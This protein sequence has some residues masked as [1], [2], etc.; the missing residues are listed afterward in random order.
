MPDPRRAS[1][2]AGRSQ[3]PAGSERPPAGAKR[4]PGAYCRGMN[5]H[6]LPCWC[7]GTP[8]PSGWR[9]CSVKVEIITSMLTFQSYRPPHWLAVKTATKPKPEARAKTPTKPKPTAW[10][11]TPTKPK[12]RARL[13]IPTK[14][15]VRVPPKPREEELVSRPLSTAQLSLRSHLP[16]TRRDVKSRPRLPARARASKCAVSMSEPPPS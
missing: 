9:K 14:P 16:K 8:R 2:D 5:S 13:K 3:P 11:K 15:E 6:S 1:A 7:N 10:V 12:P 4:K